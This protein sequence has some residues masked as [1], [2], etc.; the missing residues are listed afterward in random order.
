MDPLDFFY[1]DGVITLTNGSATATGTFTSWDPAVLPYDILNAD[2][3]IGFIATVVSAT[4]LTLAMPWQGPTMVDV[5]YVITRW[6]KHT[7]PRIYGVRVS[8]Y[9]T[10]LRAI[11]ENFE[12]V[13]AQVAADAIQTAADRTQTGLDVLATAA[14]RVQTGLDRTAASGSAASALAHYNAFRG[15][16]YGPLPSDPALDPNGAAPQAGDFYFN[17]TTGTLRIYTGTV[18]STAVL[19]AAGAVLKANNLSDLASVATA[20]TNL[21]IYSKAE[22]DARYA[23]QF[24]AEAVLV[25]GTAANFTSIPAGFRQLYAIGTRLEFSGTGVNLLMNTSSNAGSSWLAGTTGEYQ[26]FLWTGQTTFG[27]AKVTS[28]SGMLAVSN[29]KPVYKAGFELKLF[30]PDDVF[31][32][33][34][35]HISSLGSIANGDDYLYRTIMGE[36]VQASANAINAIRFVASGGTVSGKVALYGIK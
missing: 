1:S 6:I 16:Y 12:E 30:D 28:I 36:I 19:D 20:R 10:R 2:G 7:D 9:L 3:Q 5:P 14:D 4:E 24:I 27:T 17:T 33:H 18:W 8:E 29:A 26:Q 15:V 32:R 34:Q 25:N 22:A 21:S 13:G 23:P 31:P 35:I 11:P